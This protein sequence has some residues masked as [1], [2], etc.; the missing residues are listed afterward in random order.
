MSDENL[1]AIVCDEGEIITVSSD[2]LKKIPYF[3]GMFDGGYSEAITKTIDLSGNSKFACDNILAFVET[4][5]LDLPISDL[6][7]QE[8]LGLAR[9]WDVDKYIDA[10][11][12]RMIQEY[13]QSKARTVDIINYIALTEHLGTHR[14]W[15]SQQ[16]ASLPKI[17]RLH[18][19]CEE[20]INGLVAMFIE[21]PH[22]KKYL[23]PLLRDWWLLDQ[24]KSKVPVVSVL[25]EKCPVEEFSFAPR[26]QTLAFLNKF[27][28]PILAK[29]IATWAI[30]R[31]T[32]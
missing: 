29:K 27:P 12:T 15:I 9:F 30:T 22:R 24:D 16:M 21:D 19:L 8:C 13:G 6:H 17:T 25:I 28:D 26:H 18:M 10:F 14:V 2:L 5:R 31:V 3:K 11:L 4:G 7:C 23:F 32:F 20:A 1:F